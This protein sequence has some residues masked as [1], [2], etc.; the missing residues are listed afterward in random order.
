MGWRDPCI[1]QAALRSR[2]RLRRAHLSERSARTSLT[3]TRSCH[4]Q[5]G[6]TCGCHLRD[7]R[8][9][10]A[11][12]TGRLQAQRL[13]P[14]MRGEREHCMESYAVGLKQLLMCGQMLFRLRLQSFHIVPYC[15]P[16]TGGCGPLHIA[17]SPSRKLARPPPYCASGAGQN[18]VSRQ[19]KT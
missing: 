16:A 9:P 14:K 17:P 12:S 5:A 13:G 1:P 15:A 7:R 6:A 4:E 3:S 18:H 11:G 2:Q 10:L 8:V 19:G